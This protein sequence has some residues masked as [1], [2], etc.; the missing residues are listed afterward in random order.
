MRLHR[1]CNSALAITAVLLDTTV[2]P[3]VIDPIFGAVC[4]S[5]L[6]T[7]R[8]QGFPGIHRVHSPFFWYR[9]KN[10]Q[11]LMDRPCYSSLPFLHRTSTV[12]HNNSTSYTLVYM[13][14][15]YFRCNFHIA[16]AAAGDVADLSSLYDLLDWVRTACRPVNHLVS[17]CRARDD[18]CLGKSSSRALLRAPVEWRWR[19][20]PIATDSTDN[21]KHRPF[22]SYVDFWVTGRC[23]RVLCCRYSSSIVA[24]CRFL[25]CEGV[26][27]NRCRGTHGSAQAAGR[28]G[29]RHC[30][31][32]RPI[33]EH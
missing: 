14:I 6:L 9:K 25:V 8:A 11:F 17:R 23:A 10:V 21:R 13:S 7:L 2:P 26:R 29:D 27:F 32:G 5:Y 19:F 18:V 28:W 22:I 20:M 3:P 30:A 4:L 31:Q 1:V 15:S 24:L 16:A 12:C 33:S